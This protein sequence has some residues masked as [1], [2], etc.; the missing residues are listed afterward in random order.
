MVNIPTKTAGKNGQK[1]LN[2]QN[3]ARKKKLFVK[4][5][6][7]IQN[8]SIKIRKWRNQ[9]FNS[10]EESQEMTRKYSWLETTTKNYIFKQ[11]T[12]VN[13]QLAEYWYLFKTQGQQNWIMTFLF[14]NIFNS[15]NAHMF[16]KL[17]II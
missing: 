10:N 4:Q 3:I 2:Q 12:S 7:I 8:W 15:S 17:Y 6:H 1:W 9:F 13:I 14:F 11:N 16:P 5:N